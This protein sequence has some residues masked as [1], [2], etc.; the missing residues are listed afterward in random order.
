M[1]KYE[2][3]SPWRWVSKKSSLLIRKNNMYF[4]PAAIQLRN[5]QAVTEIVWKPRG[6]KNISSCSLPNGIVFIV[7]MPVGLVVAEASAI[8][9]WS[10]VDK[11]K[12]S[13]PVYFRDSEKNWYTITPPVFGPSLAAPQSQNPQRS[14][15][16]SAVLLNRHDQIWP[17]SGVDPGTSVF[18]ESLMENV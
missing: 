18:S 16:T 3:Q 10:G 9:S 15:A 5:P 12:P 1:Q 17:Q 6:R 13:M 11:S 14:A 8:F 2:N 7:K 4:A